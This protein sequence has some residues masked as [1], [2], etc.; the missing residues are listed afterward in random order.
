MADSPRK[1]PCIYLPLKL[2]TIFYLNVRASELKHI[3]QT[4]YLMNK[5]IPWSIFPDFLQLFS[6]RLPRYISMTFR[7]SPP[8]AKLSTWQIIRLSKIIYLSSFNF[9]EWGEAEL[10]GH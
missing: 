9:V 3:T 7:Q 2:Q 10:T 4:K 8:V 1:L 5:S 6:P